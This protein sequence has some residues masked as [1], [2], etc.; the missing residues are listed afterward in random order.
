M[1]E[2]LIGPYKTRNVKRLDS[3]GQRARFRA[4][5]QQVGYIVQSIRAYAVLDEIVEAERFI[6]TEAWRIQSNNKIE[7]QGDDDFLIPKQWVENHSGRFVIIARAWY[8]RSLDDDFVRGTSDD[9][10][11]R[12]VGTPYVKLPP[13]G[14]QVLERV[15]MA[16]W[17]KGGEVAF[18]KIR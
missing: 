6:Y 16:S 3:I 4:R 2:I 10:W 5:P 13:N 12:L 9:L 17:V 15:W 11:G 7:Q 8:Q 14:A 1:V 18:E